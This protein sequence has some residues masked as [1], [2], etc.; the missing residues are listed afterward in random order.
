MEAMSE[1]VGR[2]TNDPGA[3]RPRTS[4]AADSSRTPQRAVR[5]PGQD[6][7]IRSAVREHGLT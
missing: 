2:L 6:S 3:Y 7:A 5:L 4:S 1:T